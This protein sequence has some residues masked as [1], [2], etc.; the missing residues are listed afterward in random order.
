MHPDEVPTSVALVRRLVS[1]QFPE[2]SML[3]VERV[4]SFGT[5][6]A[7]YRLGSELVARL[8][9]REVNEGR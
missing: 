3:P 7:L 6:H 4:A 2:L 9:R 1:E 5:D 8:P